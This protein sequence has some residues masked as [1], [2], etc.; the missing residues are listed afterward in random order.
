MLAVDHEGVN[1]NNAGTKM[2]VGLGR[3]LLKALR[4]ALYVFLLLLGRVLLPV[5]NFATLIGIVVFLFCLLVRPD[6]STP[7]WAGAGLAVSATA[8]S[9][10]YEAALR[11]VAP[12]DVVIL[13]EL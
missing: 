13:S 1:M 4:F 7:M 2:I 6:L 10:F 11:L 12:S 3:G 5:A 9:V 8:V